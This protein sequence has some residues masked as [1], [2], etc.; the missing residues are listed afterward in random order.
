MPG[1]SADTILVAV[2]DAAALAAAVFAF[3][4]LGQAREAVREAHRE[5]R[6]AE[7]A[8]LARRV[9]WAGE[10]IEQIDRL[11]WDDLH[12][13]PPADTWRRGRFLLA[14]G[15]VGLAGRLPQ[16]AK[17]VD[18]CDVYQVRSNAMLAREEVGRELEQ[19]AKQQAG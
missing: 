8:R 19:L 13:T 1:M 11:A 14:Q 6:E 17:L 9:E 10:M 5:R 2:G 3:L 7:R 16:T 4:A 15:F 12:V 18:S